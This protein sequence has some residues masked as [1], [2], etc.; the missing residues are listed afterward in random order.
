[1]YKNKKFIIIFLIALSIPLVYKF[2]GYFSFF[3]P[4]LT[5]EYS[6]NSEVEMKKTIW[7]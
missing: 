3:R 6:A 7:K 4:G 5:T 1:M 2:S